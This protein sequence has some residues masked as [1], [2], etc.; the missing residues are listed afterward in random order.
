MTEREDGRWNKKSEWTT[1]EPGLGFTFELGCYLSNFRFAVSIVFLVP[2]VAER[3]EEIIDARFQRVRGTVG[4]TVGSSLRY[5]SK[6]LIENKSLNG[7]KQNAS[8]DTSNSS[9]K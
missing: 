2:L 7:D 8:R 9:C 5:T 3:L 4:N 1:Y 6:N